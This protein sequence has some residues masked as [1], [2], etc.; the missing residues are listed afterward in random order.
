MPP[1]LASVWKLEPRLQ[2]SAVIF[3]I[4]NLFIPSDLSE[5]F[6]FCFEK[7]RPKYF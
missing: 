2:I 4:C 7:L 1:S 3:A 6:T 5:Y